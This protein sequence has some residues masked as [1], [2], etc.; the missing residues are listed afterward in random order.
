MPSFFSR[1]IRAI[2]ELLTSFFGFRVCGVF[3]GFL[4]TRLVLATQVEISRCVGSRRMPLSPGETPRL[5]GRRDGRRYGS[6]AVAVARCAPP[7]KN[8]QT[9]DNSGCH[10][11]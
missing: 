5:C 7:G 1:A 6:S 10:W 4:L 9:P 11:I 3:R 8:F 2:R